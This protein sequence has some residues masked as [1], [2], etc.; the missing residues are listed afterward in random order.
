MVTA[1]TYQ[2]LPRFNSRHK[3]EFLRAALFELADKH[4]LLLQAWAIFPNHYHFLAHIERATRLGPFVQ[5]LH[6]KTGAFLND[7]D[8]TAGRR[9]WFQYWDSKITFERSYYARL[10]YVHR[11]AVHHGIVKVAARYPW[12]SAGW[13]EREAER[14]FRD[15]VLRFRSDSVNVVDDFDV[16]RSD[17]DLR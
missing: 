13:F 12:C 1:A 16:Q 5:R 10:N 3:L 2:K 7:V 6:A 17:F 8:K 9:V 4:G 14:S 15:T 11:N